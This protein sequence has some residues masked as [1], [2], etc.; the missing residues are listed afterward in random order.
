M[1]L[2]CDKCEGKPFQ[3]FFAHCPLRRRRSPTAVTLQASSYHAVI[4]L[5]LSTFTLFCFLPYII[6]AQHSYT[7]HEDRNHRSVLLVVSSLLPLPP[8]TFFPPLHSSMLQIIWL[9]LEPW[10]APSPLAEQLQMR[11]PLVRCTSTKASS[12]GCPC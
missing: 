1:G 7:Q 8:S 12:D 6:H 9:A 5:A 10:E 11:V 2:T 4:H 3:S